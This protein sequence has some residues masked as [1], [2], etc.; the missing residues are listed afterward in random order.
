VATVLELALERL[1]RDL[2]KER[3]ARTD[4]PRQSRSAPNPNSRH[5][6]HQVRRE[7]V[8][9]DQERCT[10]VSADGHR[11]KATGMLEF[12]HI[13][14][15]ARGGLPTTDKIRLLCRAHNQLHAEQTFG[16]TFMKQA[17]A[18]RDSSQQTLWLTSQDPEPHQA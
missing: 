16:R 6:P 1:V 15:F 9:R 18:R 8:E 12:D 10:F 11:C 3:F 4:R 2:M 13:D 5:I 14:A 7:V 17:R